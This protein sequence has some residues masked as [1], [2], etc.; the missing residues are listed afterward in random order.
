M[1]HRHCKRE[2]PVPETKHT[3]QHNPTQNTNMSSI[4]SIHRP[5]KRALPISRSLPFSC[6]D[7]LPVS[8][9]RDWTLVMSGIW[10]RYLTYLWLTIRSFFFSLFSFFI[11]LVLGFLFSWQLVFLH[12]FTV[13]IPLR[14]VLYLA[15]GSRSCFLLLLGW[16]GREL[17]RGFGFFR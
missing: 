11:P 12:A 17:R 4:D 3:Q 2:A 8:Q 7:L 16:H 10:L 15:C 13:R 14:T 9:V 1:H 5:S 6:F